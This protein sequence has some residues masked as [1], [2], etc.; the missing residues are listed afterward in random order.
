LNFLQS[1]VPIRYKKSSQLVSQDVHSNTANY[2]H[3]FSVEMPPL[4]KD[5]LICL[6]MK[7][8]ATC[9]NISPLV[10]CHKVTN[11]LYFIDPFT[12]QLAEMTNQYWHYEF[13]TLADRR[14]L[15]EFVIL[16]I[17]LLGPTV[18]ARG[19]TQFA[20]AEAT[21]AR[22]SDL[23][24]NDKTFYTVTHLGNI[25]NPGDTCA[26]YD[27]ST[28]N[29]NEA[30]LTSLKGRRLRSEIILVRK[31]YPN[32]RKH[33]RARHWE[34][35]KLTVEP[36]DMRRVDIEKHERAV[37]EFMQDLEEDLEMRS[38]VNLYK[39]K[40]GPTVTNDEMDVDDAP[41]EEDFPE[42]KIEELL[43]MVENLQLGTDDK[44]DAAQ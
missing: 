5:D 26:G 10:L 29:F 18:T 13:T 30:Y 17:E 27:L 11:T 42:V 7:L 41:P 31:T 39:S 38:G 2:K 3:T 14:R 21:V 25:L 32:R 8:S 33:R 4:C 1:I 6:P 20:L 19:R 9:G 28:A 15:S 36:M 16:D 37:E 23:G 34:L 35:A 22:T 40:T 43:D 12:L 44:D 24:F